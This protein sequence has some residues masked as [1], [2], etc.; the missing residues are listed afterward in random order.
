[1][2]PGPY[3]INARSALQHAVRHGKLVTCTGAGR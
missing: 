2:F 3:S 1:M